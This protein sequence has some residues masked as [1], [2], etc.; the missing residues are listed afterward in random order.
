MSCGVGCNCVLDL[1]WLCLWLVAVAPIQDLAWEL[2]HAMCVALKSKKKKKK[3]MFINIKAACLFFNMRS[4]FNNSISF[5]F[6][7]S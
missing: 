3:K 2:P 5:I 4:F 7:Y 1:V 6:Y